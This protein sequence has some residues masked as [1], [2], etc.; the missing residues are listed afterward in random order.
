[1][2]QP[3]VIQGTAEELI[4][5]LKNSL[6]Y[7]N[8]TLIIPQQHL[9]KSAATSYPEGAVI[10]NGVRLFPIAGRTTVT[11]EMVKQLMDEEY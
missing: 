4:A 9:E 5:Y 1:M 3:Q 2:T 7:T 6:D 8:L 11:T 10:R